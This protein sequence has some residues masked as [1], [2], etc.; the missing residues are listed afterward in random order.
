[1]ESPFSKVLAIATVQDI[2]LELM[3]R[4]KFNA[5]DGERVVASLLAQ[6]PLW[7]A[8]LMDRF[9]LAN[10]PRLPS[11]GLIKLRDLAANIWNVDTLY[12]L[13]PNPDCARKLAKIV[14]NEDWGGMVRVHCDWKDVDSALG[15][16]EDEQAIVSIWW[17]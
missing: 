15:G 12:I 17:D 9:C 13:A 7:Q 4:T 16:A 10:G 6:K 14:E 5:F 11:C 8:V 3:R 2:Q 1:M